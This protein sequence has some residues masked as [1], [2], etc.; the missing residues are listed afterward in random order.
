MEKDV[1][2]E[3]I[4]KDVKKITD[5][6]LKSVQEKVNAINQVQMQVGGLEVQK[7]VALESIKVSQLELQTIQKTLE[8]KY[9]KVS[10]NLQDGTIT[11]IPEEN[12]T[13]KK[14]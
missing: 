2:V 12:E 1:K 5:E 13:D 3:D 11:E 8:E 10:V 7:T 4:A 9:G 14:D 6:E